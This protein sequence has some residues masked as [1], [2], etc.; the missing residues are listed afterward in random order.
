MYFVQTKLV[1]LVYDDNRRVLCVPTH[2]VLF[3][4]ISEVNTRKAENN[5]EGLL[6]KNC[7]INL[8]LFP[9]PFRSTADRERKTW[10]T[11]NRRNSLKITVF[12]F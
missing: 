3:L 4:S 6:K 12:C 10:E 2:L 1:S 8:R 7:Q 9:F 11:N 5:W